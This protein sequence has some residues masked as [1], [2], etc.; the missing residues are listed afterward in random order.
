MMWVKNVVLDRIL[1]WMDRPLPIGALVYGRY[2]I[3]DYLGMGSYGMSYV[4]QDH[5]DNEKKLLKQQRKRLKVDNQSF[6]REK[7]MLVSLTH[8][9]VPSL[10]DSFRWE[11]KEFIVMTYFPFRNLEDLIFAD[12][13]RF[14]EVEAF[15]LVRGVLSTAAYA[16]NQGIVHCDLRIPNIL[17]DG[18]DSYIIDFGLAKRLGEVALD[19]ETKESYV[20]SVQ[21][22]LYLLGHFTLFLLYSSYEESSKEEKPWQ[23]ELSLSR[24]GKEIIERM[25]EIQEP[26]H[27]MALLLQ[28]IDCVIEGGSQ[29]VVL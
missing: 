11:K 24:A 27:D 6:K 25:L 29:D 23:E 1:Q 7:E 14:S 9:R 16:H 22:D 2:E 10:L 8:E 21:E 13:Y 17:F 12:G 4:V 3:I 28:H 15:R 18:V 20:V 19:K 5:K 26:Y